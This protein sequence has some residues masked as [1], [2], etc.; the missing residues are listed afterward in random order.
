MNVCAS[1]S[2][3]LRKLCKTCVRVP[4]NRASGQMFDFI[5]VYCVMIFS[6]PLLSPVR[7]HNRRHRL[8]SRAP[9]P[10]DRPNT[11]AAAV[12]LS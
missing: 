6:C 2:M 4:Q 9:M 10:R 12:S 7:P 8:A 5:A 1:I 11:P 3:T